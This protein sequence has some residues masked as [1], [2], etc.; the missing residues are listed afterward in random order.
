MVTTHGRAGRLDG[1]VALVTGGASGLGR[2]IVERF[3]AEGA[4][5]GVLDRSAEG[6]DVVR[7]EHRERVVVTQGDVRDVDA[8]ERAVS[9]CVDAFGKLDCAIANAGIWDYSRLLVDLDPNTL[10]AGF[11][12]V[13]S[14]NAKGPVL[15]ARASLPALV[16]S[17]GSFLVTISNAGFYP[18]GGGALYTMSKHALVGL[19]RQLAFEWA[20][21][22]RVNG[23]AP[24]PIETDLRGP[25]SLGLD[26]RPISSL[27]LA[28]QAT[29]F[30][31]LGRVPT[32]EEYASAY[33]FFAARGEAAPATGS[34]LNLDGGLGVRGLSRLSRG[35]D[36]R[37]RFQY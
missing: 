22:V 18:D 30:V 11:D 23:I 32:P 4:R 36:L 7:R 35:G 9:A 24:G 12:E 37:S 17:S 19:V 8:N 3:V 1:E 28:E 15:L 26:E 10:A 16:R 14:V 34:I 2:A 33:V 21:A 5:V 6:L 29:S 27:R 25:A 31:P 20:P 13:M